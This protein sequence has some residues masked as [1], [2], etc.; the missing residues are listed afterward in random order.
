M[1]LALLGLLMGVFLVTSLIALFVSLVAML[2]AAIFNRSFSWLAVADA[3]GAAFRLELILL[4]FLG[5]PLGAAAGP[6]GGWLVAILITA[7]VGSAAFTYFL[8]ARIPY[9]CTWRAWRRLIVWPFSK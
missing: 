1:L 3:L 8:L 5:V 7:V 4:V 2:V 9:W 6:Y